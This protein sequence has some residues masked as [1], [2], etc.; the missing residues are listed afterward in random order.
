MSQLIAKGWSAADY[1][2]KEF[3]VKVSNG[4]KSRYKAAVSEISVSNTKPEEKNQ[5]PNTSASCEE[6]S[7]ELAAS[8]SNKVL[9]SSQVSALVSLDRVV[10]NSDV[11][12][13]TVDEVPIRSN[14]ALCPIQDMHETLESSVINTLFACFSSVQHNGEALVD[15]ED[16]RIIEMWHSTS[17]V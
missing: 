6:K 3:C 17:L 11:S 2:T 4:C 14:E 1:E 9:V 13:D 8:G 10:S 15:V 5:V 16:K 12:R 7:V